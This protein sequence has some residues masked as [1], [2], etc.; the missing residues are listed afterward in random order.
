MCIFGSALVKIDFVKLIL[1]GKKFWYFNV[2]GVVIIVAECV[3]FGST[4]KRIDYVK[5]IL[6]RSGWV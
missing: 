2:R 1:G 4:V 3:M 5:L 6:V